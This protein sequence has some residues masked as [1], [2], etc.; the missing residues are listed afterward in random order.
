MSACNTLFFRM[1]WAKKKFGPQHGMRMRTIDIGLRMQGKVT[2]RAE[3]EE[4]D[5]YLIPEVSLTRS[6]H[7]PLTGKKRQRQSDQLCTTK[8]ATAPTSRLQPYLANTLGIQDVRA[9]V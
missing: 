1:I 2:K 9:A 4:T 6:F 8:C 3:T 7:F 5:Y